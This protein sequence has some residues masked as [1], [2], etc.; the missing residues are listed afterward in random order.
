MTLPLSYLQ[1]SRLGII[2]QVLG[3]EKTEVKKLFALT[4]FLKI[5]QIF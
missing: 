5:E 3:S 4:F 2:D 1:I